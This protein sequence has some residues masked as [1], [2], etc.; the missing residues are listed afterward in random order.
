MVKTNRLNGD[1]MK[2]LIIGMIALTSLSA[3]ASADCSLSLS[4][5]PNY[6]EPIG[7]IS[8]EEMNSEVERL[9]SAKGYHLVKSSKAGTKME[10]D[11]VIYMNNH[12]MQFRQADAY[13]V[14]NG[15]VTLDAYSRG[16]IF[17]KDPRAMT[18]NAI[19]KLVKQLPVCVE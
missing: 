17:N 4:K 14:N 15:S 10:I 13:T 5:G 2:S 11:F 7:F 18:L 8:F 1:I 16:S 3:F 19:K 6:H 9:A 12:Y